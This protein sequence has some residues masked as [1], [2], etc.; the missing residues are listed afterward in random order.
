MVSRSQHA[1]CSG[2]AGREGERRHARYRFVAGPPEKLG[3]FLKSEIA[4][5]A[6]AAK[7]GA[8]K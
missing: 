5:R 2:A 3:E 1:R 7:R 6:D 4:K 8:F